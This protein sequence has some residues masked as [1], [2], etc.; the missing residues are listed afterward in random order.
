MEEERDGAGQHQMNWGEREK[1]VQSGE[2][3]VG[4]GLS[5]RS[6]DKSP[7]EWSNDDLGLHVG[8]EGIEWRE[9]RIRIV[10]R[11][12]IGRGE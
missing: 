12:R 3:R 4:A 1:E 5:A 8:L 9:Q 7:A 6:R 10:G 11:E 2:L